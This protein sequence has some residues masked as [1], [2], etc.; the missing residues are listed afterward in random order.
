MGLTYLDS[1]N[2]CYSFCNQ[3]Q[4]KPK[5]VSVLDTLFEKINLII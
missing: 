3:S 1:Q 4:I 2:A 5:R